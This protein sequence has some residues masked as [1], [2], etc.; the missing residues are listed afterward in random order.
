MVYNDLVVRF[1]NLF[2]QLKPRRNQYVAAGGRVTVQQARE[3]ELRVVCEGGVKVA[4]EEIARP[5]PKPRPK[6]KLRATPRRSK[7]AANHP[8][9]QPLSAKKHAAKRA[10]TT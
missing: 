7:P 8:W 9:R 2:L 3:G 10:A 6:P 4:F 1:E 5:Q